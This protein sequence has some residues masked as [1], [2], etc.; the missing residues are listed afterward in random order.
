MPFHIQITEKDLGMTSRGAEEEKLRGIMNLLHTE[1]HLIESMM[2][3]PEK[4]EELTALIDNVRR[5]RQDLVKSWAGQKVNPNFWCATKHALETQRHVEEMIENA[6]RTE[7]EK[8]PELL[9][10]LKEVVNER[11]KIIEEF[12]SGEGSIEEVGEMVCKRCIADFEEKSSQSPKIEQEVKK[13]GGGLGYIEWV[14]V[15]GIGVL[16]LIAIAKRPQQ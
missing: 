12:K 2:A 10:S 7:R 8:V 9:K 6:A 13:T 11:N 5:T 14:L 15:L 1:T 3:H 4:T 16:G